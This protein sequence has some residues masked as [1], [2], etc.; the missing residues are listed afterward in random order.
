MASERLQTFTDNNFENS[1]TKSPTPVL[2]D[3]WA[4]WCGPCLR[5][6]PAVEAVAAEFDGKLLVG[7]VNV[8]ENPGIAMKYDIRGIPTLLLFKG[9]QVIDASVGLVGKEDLKRMVQKHI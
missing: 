3:F 1:V 4:E 2:V 9:G 6:A 5:L 8:D 7:K